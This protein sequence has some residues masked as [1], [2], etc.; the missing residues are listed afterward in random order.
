MTTGWRFYAKNSSISIDTTADPN[1]Y[2][3]EWVHI[4]GTFNATNISIYFNGIKQGE[5]SSHGGH[6]STA[7]PAF[8]MAGASYFNGTI[9]EVKI[10]NRSLTATE[11][12]QE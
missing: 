6:E 11:I 4:V 12:K 7:T 2:E 5:T 3:D 10:W 9:D 1:D 8:A